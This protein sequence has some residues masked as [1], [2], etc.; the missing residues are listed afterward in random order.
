MKQYD[1][2]FIGIVIDIFSMSHVGVG[3]SLGELLPMLLLKRNDPVHEVL[4]SG[5]KENVCRVGNGEF[6]GKL[7][8]GILGLCNKSP[9]MHGVSAIFMWPL[10]ETWVLDSRRRSWPRKLKFG[11]IFDFLSLMNSYASSNESL[12]TVIRYAKQMVTDRDIPAL[13][14]TKTLPFCRLTD[15]IIKRRH[16]MKL[17]K[18]NKYINK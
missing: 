11:E 6:F 9:V 15:S 7:S 17:Q 16:Q 5:G 14:W 8:K 18:I 1:I 13:Q 2:R 4:L 10:R 3:N 12:F